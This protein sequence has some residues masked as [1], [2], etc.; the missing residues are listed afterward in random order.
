MRTKIGDVISR[1]RNQVKSVNQDAFLT[2]RFIYSI[3]LKHAAWLLKREDGA[4][5]LMK[6]NSAFQVLSFVELIE[7]DKIEA[8]CVGLKSNCVIKRTKD[9]LPIFMEGYWGPLVRSVTSIDSSEEVHP[10]NPSTYIKLANTKTAKYNKTLYYWT[11][12]DYFYFPNLE[13]EAIK[14]EGIF[15]DDISAYNCSDCGD[16]ITCIPRQEQSFNVPDYLLGELEQ[17][18]V[19]DMMFKIQAPSD[20]VHD[21]QNSIRP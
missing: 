8:H 19:K 20:P 9:K 11:I 14:M 21:K 12:N 1:I 7:V 17:N 5:K 13:W 10:T 3:M 4:Y 2:D 16:D 18:V 15:Q 6:F